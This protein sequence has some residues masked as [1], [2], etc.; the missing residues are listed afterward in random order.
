MVPVVTGLKAV[1]KTS[2]FVVPTPT[3]PTPV[4][5]NT[6]VLMPAGVLSIL[7][8]SPSPFWTM[9]TISSDVDPENIPALLSDGGTT[10]NLAFG[11]VL[12]IP[13]FPSM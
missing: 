8:E 11:S 4:T 9:R 6:D 3:V 12:P 2:G 10:S 1:N 13:V 5:T 7:N